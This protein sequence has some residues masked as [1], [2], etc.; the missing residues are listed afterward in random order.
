MCA[1]VLCNVGSPS[2][3]QPLQK[4]NLWHDTKKPSGKQDGSGAACDLC[5]AAL[6]RCVPLFLDTQAAQACCTLA[7]AQPVA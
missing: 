5:D 1:L 7:K 4:L 2:M 6:R 3:L